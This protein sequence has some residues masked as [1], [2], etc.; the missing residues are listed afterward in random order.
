MLNASRS[1]WESH[2]KY[3]TQS[4]DSN[5]MQYLSILIYLLPVAYPNLHDCKPD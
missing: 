5:N 2:K 1:F 3:H 4:T